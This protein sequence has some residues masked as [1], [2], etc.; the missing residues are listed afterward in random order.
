MSSLSGD[1]LGSSFTQVLDVNYSRSPLSANTPLSGDS[2]ASSFPKV[3]DVSYSPSPLSINTPLSGDSVA[4]SFPKV[5]D[6]SYSPSPLSANTPLSSSFPAVPHFNTTSSLS[7]SGG[8]LSQLSDGLSS[9]SSRGRKK[10]RRRFN[11][12]TSTSGP[13]S[14]LSS[15]SSNGHKKKRSRTLGPNAM[16]SLQTEAIL[17][18]TPGSSVHD[19]NNSLV[20][21]RDRRALSNLFDVVAQERNNGGNDGENMFHATSNDNVNNNNSNNTTTVFDEDDDN[22]IPTTITNQNRANICKK[23]GI[24]VTTKNKTI[25][26]ILNKIEVD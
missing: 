24:A 25:K 4:S 17:F 6:A 26:K 5:L 18:A 19:S 14:S 16:H 12:N 9:L 11:F 22:A 7:S 21:I 3:L 20:G 23:L 1:S 8:S 13:K 15:S 2:L 10:K